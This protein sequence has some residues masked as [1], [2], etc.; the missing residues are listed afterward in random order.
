MKLPFLVVTWSCDQNHYH[1]STH[2]VFKMAAKQGQ[3]SLSNY[4]SIAKKSKNISEDISESDDNKEVQ[5]H[6]SIE[7]TNEP[8]P[9]S[10]T[11]GEEESSAILEVDVCTADCCREDQNEPYQPDSK[12]KFFRR[13]SE[14]RARGKVSKPDMFRY[15]RLRSTH[16]QHCVQAD[17][18]YTATFAQRHSG[19]I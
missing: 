2:H 1:V 17:R 4:F 12:K 9:S 11:F 15:N 5:D 6:S 14:F 18:N 13:Q 3:Q 8:M 19:H 7:H 16:G 10:S